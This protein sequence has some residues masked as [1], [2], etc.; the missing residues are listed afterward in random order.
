MFGN[1]LFIIS[2]SAWWITLH[3][4]NAYYLL[5]L[6]SGEEI[7]EAS[8]L[9]DLAHDD[10]VTCVTINDLYVF[11]GRELEEMDHIPAGNI[12]GMVLFK[13]KTS[14][15]G[16]MCWNSFV[17]SFWCIIDRHLS[18]WCNISN[19]SKNVL[20]TI[21]SYGHEKIS[22]FCFDLALHTWYLKS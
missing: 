18:L 1:G 4:F 11:M 21:N 15:I 2:F 16:K 6:Q 19:S 13:K 14:F 7:K 5:Q 10:H 17:R 20:L 22:M 9:Q 8:T 12:L 3:L